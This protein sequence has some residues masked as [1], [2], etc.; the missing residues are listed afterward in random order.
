MSRK[1][2]P[3]A[4]ALGGIPPGIFGFVDKELDSF[5][6][7]LGG[8]TATNSALRWGITPLFIFQGVAPGPQHSMFA[9][10]MDTQTPG[11]R[12]EM[13]YQHDIYNKTYITFHSISC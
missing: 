4:D 11:F 13:Q 10:R 12:C 3:F 7:P 5:K 6:E 8:V 1:E 9:S 2:D